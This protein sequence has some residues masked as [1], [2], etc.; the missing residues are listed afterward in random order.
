MTQK[1]RFPSLV[2]LPATAPARL[3]RAVVGGGHSAD[4]GSTGPA[5]RS[6]P[7]LGLLLVTGM[8]AFD[9]IDAEGHP[10]WA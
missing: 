5:A 6:A 7:E 2:Q 8:P 3:V 4:D 10:H 1:N 9:L